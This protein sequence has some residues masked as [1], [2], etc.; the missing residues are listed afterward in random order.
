MTL[1]QKRYPDTIRVI[2]SGYA[3]QTSV[4]RTVGPAHVYLAKPCTPQQLMEVIARPLAVRNLL[5]APHLRRAVSGLSTLPNAP[6]T[7]LALE[8]EIRSPRSSAA[9]IAAVISR[10]VAMTA[11]IL[12]LTNSAY[13]ALSTRVA[14]PLQA[15]QLLGI[16]TVQSL[17]LQVG[18]FRQFH[19][20]TR[21]APLIESLNKYSL[22]IADLAQTITNAEK[23]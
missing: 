4:M 11:E 9:S 23:A 12:K 10:D 14:T 17:V 6:E 5:S 1:V 13:F 22:A 19:G 20:N 3:D 8:K 18:I 16:E 2:L 21:T 7:F 15:V